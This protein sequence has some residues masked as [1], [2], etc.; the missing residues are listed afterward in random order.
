VESAASLSIQA[1]ARIDDAGVAMACLSY[2]DAGSPAHMRYAVRRLRR[3]MPQA[4]ILLGC[5]V[6]GMD[7]AAAAALREAVRADLVATSLREA[8]AVCLEVAKTEAAEG[9]N[10]SITVSVA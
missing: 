3:K 8:M 2:L 6:E 1:V 7:A 5:W 4:Q 10:G 9:L